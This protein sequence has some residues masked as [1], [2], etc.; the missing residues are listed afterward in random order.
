MLA[1]SD[2]GRPWIWCGM[3][4]RFSRELASASAARSVVSR[5]TSANSSPPARAQKMDGVWKRRSRSATSRSSVA[6]GVAEGV[7]D[8]LEA[9]QVQEQHGQQRALAAQAGGGLGD[10]AGQR[11][12]ELAAVGQA[13]QVVVRGLVAQLRDLG[14]HV[15]HIAQHQDDAVTRRKGARL[16][17]GRQ[18]RVVAGMG[19][20]LAGGGD[21]AAGVVVA[22]AGQIGIAVPDVVAGQFGQARSAPRPGSDSARAIPDRAR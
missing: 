19:R 8:F 5:N 2:T 18:R 6:L 15:R 17:P 4:S 16:E 13:G 12:H 3:D 11:V 9:V 10:G 7:V 1:P 20:R 14:V 21:G 22:R